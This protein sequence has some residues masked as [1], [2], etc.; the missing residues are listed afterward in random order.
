MP[1]EVK[2]W[3]CSHRPR[4]ARLDH[5]AMLP[6]RKE[7]TPIFL[8]A[9]SPQV[10]LAEDSR[11]RC[12][13]PALPGTRSCPGL[14]RHR[15]PRLQQSVLWRRSLGKTHER[16]SLQRSNIPPIHAITC[17]GQHAVFTRMS[18]HGPSPQFWA[19]PF[20][21]STAAAALPATGAAPGPGELL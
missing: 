8:R 3:F 7:G 6:L 4:Q 15:V 10:V 18:D 21:R 2:E 9:H 5:G 17:G 19:H 16:S 14:G 13:P 1:P 12:W 11:Y 20:Q